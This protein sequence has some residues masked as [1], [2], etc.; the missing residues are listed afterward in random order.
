MPELTKQTD[1]MKNREFQLF[2]RDACAYGF[3]LFEL[4]TTIVISVIPIS[5]VGIL[6]VGGQRNWNQMYLSAN[7]QIKID[8]QTVATV[9]CDMGR[10]AS[11]SDSVII[12]TLGKELAPSGPDPQL[13]SG[14]AV[15]FRFWRHNPTGKGS[16]FDP[17]PANQPTDYA[18]FYHNTEDNTLNVDYGPYP[19][20]TRIIASTKVL[21]NNVTSLSFNQMAFNGVRQ[22]CIRMNLV[23]TDTDNN[24]T[25]TTMATA[26]MRN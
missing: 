21:A 26:L 8:A 25:T 4:M 6:L 23:L 10:D 16:R 5:V 14:E 9:F 17:R 20:N 1:K 22:G 11:R 13:L 15:E 7:K 24:E 12:S 2:N 19:Y 3:T 18:R